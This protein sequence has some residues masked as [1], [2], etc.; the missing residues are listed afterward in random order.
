MKRKYYFVILFFI[1]AI[2]LSGCSGITTPILEVNQEEK[3]KE[4]VTNYWSAMSNSQYELA[5]T[6]CMSYGYFYGLAF[7]GQNATYYNY[8]TAVFTPVINWV[9]INGNK[10]TVKAN[11]IMDTNIG[12]I[13]LYDYTMGLIKIGSAWKLE[14]QLI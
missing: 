7:A 12:S 3:V 11:L 10:A 8:V 14:E 13:T 2:F 4:T 5:K 1:L 9:E 6:Y